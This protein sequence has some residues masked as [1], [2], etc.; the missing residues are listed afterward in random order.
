MTFDAQGNLY[1]AASL[2]G[3]KGIVRIAP[4]QQAHL[5][6]S[7]AGL[8]GVAFTAGRSLILANTSSIFHLNWDVRG[9]PLLS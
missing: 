5:A 6:V 7:G 3:R 2:G 8:V 9:L 4:D 1:V